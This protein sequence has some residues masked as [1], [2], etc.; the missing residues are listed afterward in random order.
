[1]T[2]FTCKYQQVKF[3]EAIC[4]RLINKLNKDF[5]SNIKSMQ[6]EYGSIIGGYEEITDAMMYM[7]RNNHQIFAINEDQF[8]FIDLNN[9]HKKVSWSPIENTSSFS[10][11]LSIV[12]LLV[13]ENPT[14]LL[15]NERE[16]LKNI[17]EKYNDNISNFLEKNS[18]VGGEGKIQYDTLWH[19]E[20]IIYEKV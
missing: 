14:Y 5:D 2:M 3:I 9:K 20:I 12:D 6:F 1:M 17:R 4:N 10:L 8:I 15:V 11:A 7:F 13:R 19:D 18:H 16:Y